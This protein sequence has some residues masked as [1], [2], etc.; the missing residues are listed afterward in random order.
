MASLSSSL[1]ITF[2]VIFL[3][4]VLVACSPSTGDG[5]QTGSLLGGTGAT[6]GKR[7]QGMLTMSA[8]KDAANP[9][10]EIS[11][12]I[13][14]RNNTPIDF[15]DAE[16]NVTI[17]GQKLRITDT[18]GGRQVDDRISWSI[19]ALA[20][21]E[22]MN[23]LYRGELSELLRQGDVVRTVVSLR[24][25]N[26][27]NPATAQAE[28]R[29]G[30]GGVSSFSGSVLSSSASSSSTNSGY[31]FFLGEEGSS[32]SLSSLSSV[33]SSSSVA[34]PVPVAGTVTVTNRTDAAERP[35]G[36]A[37]R[38][39]IT[40]RNTSASPVANLTVEALLPAALLVTNA[41]GGAHAEDAI[42]WTLPS[43]GAGQSR[44]F[45]YRATLSRTVLPGDVVTTIA[46]V[47]SPAFSAPLI[48]TADV[49]IVA[50][51]APLPQSG[52][53][54]KF[55]RPPEDTSKYLRKLK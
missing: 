25:G 33:S 6:G 30:A 2:A 36:G 44:T 21:G 37:V 14:V 16:V 48:A 18:A 20:S 41:G 47:N 55:F 1:R 28:I 10:E 11:F 12:L 50:G 4:L 26:L 46:E 5:T 54:D 17:P 31:T 51:A 22:M 39:S 24:A 29:I 40:V 49:R 23:L 38:Y 19:P 34:A 9:G 52:V 45:A 43:L 42:T 32:S 13:T 35:A 27:A 53:E 7:E 8:N 15:Q 3:P